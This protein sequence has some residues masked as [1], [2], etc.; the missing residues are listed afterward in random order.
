MRM[1]LRSIIFPLLCICLSL[2]MAN[3]QE[4]LTFWTTEGEKDRIE[5]QKNIA[6]QFEKKSGIRVQVVP[7]EENLLAKRITAAYA[8]KSLP[9]V[10]FHPLAHTI[11]WFDAGILEKGPSTEAINELGKETFG[12]GPLNL[13][14]VPGGYAAVPADGWGQFLLYRKD[15]FQEKGLAKPEWMV[16][17]EAMAVIE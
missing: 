11:G 13:A 17:I 9:D 12:T 8:A 7:V 1:T 6:L 5:I 4:N 15:L 3:A 2:N 14:Q 10:V 16:E